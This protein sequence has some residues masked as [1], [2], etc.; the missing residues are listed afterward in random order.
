MSTKFK[1]I[2]ITGA[3]SGIGEALA[4]Y[5]AAAGADNL[6]LCGRNE[7]RLNKV[8][9][10]CAGRGAKVF[11]EILDV[12]NKSAMEKWIEVC[13]LTAPLNLV[14]ANAGVATIEET[15]ENVRRTFETNVF[16]VV[17]TVLPTVEIFKQAYGRTEKAV[18]LLASIAGYHGLPSCPSYSASKACV[19]AWGEALRGSLREEGIAVSIICP[20][21]VKSRITDKNT[22][23]M[24]FFWPADKA[25]AVIAARL[26]RNV[27][28]IA[29][30]WPM[31]LATWLM[32]ILPNALSDFIYARLPHKV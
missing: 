20:G 17:N 3:S 27:G 28:I 1:N 25:A 6:F 16:G 31:R 11:A 8:A 22:C 24:P 12:T 5:Y 7:E 23:P 4:L 14:I 13:E 2:L 30:P 18:A 10:E 32:S 21:F 26:E 9:A 15:S 29:F 19:K